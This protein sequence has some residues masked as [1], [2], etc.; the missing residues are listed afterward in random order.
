[1]S[2][3]YYAVQCQN[4]DC[5]EAIFPW[6]PLPLGMLSPVYKSAFKKVHCPKCGRFMKCIGEIGWDK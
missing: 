2:K 5:K 6:I 3:F 1:M 4:A